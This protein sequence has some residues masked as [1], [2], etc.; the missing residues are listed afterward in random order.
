M[1]SPNAKPAR[2]RVGLAAAAAAVVLGAC[3]AAPAGPST[4]GAGGSAASSVAPAGSVPAVATSMHVPI[5]NADMTA[6]QIKAEV[7][8]EGELV[9]AN[10]SF[11][12]DG[13]MTQEFKD[14]IK[15]TYGAD[16]NFTYEGSF[17]PSVYLTNIYAAQ[18]GGNPAPYD[19]MAV[20]ENYWADAI[21]HDAVNS[22]LPS[23]LVP[24]QGL[25]LDQFQR[26]PT[27]I[28]FQAAAYPAVNYN[29]SAAPFITKLTDLAD[30]RLKGKVTLP[31]PGDITAGG[32]FMDLAA[33]LNKDYKDPDQ[34]KQ[35]VDWA[36]ANIGPNVL[37]YTS[38]QAEISQLLESGT[39]D[40]AAFWDGIN[41]SEAFNGHPE[42]ALLVPKVAYSV[43]GYMWIPKGAQHP[44]LAQIWI[45]WRLS[46]EVQFPNN[47]PGISHADWATWNEGELGPSYASS[48][49]SWFTNYATAYPTL[50][51]MSSYFKTVDWPAYN[52][53]VKVWMDYYASK[54]GQ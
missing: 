10:W 35:V 15:A 48:V 8:K 9:V 13:V 38:D 23:P 31:S 24:N 28:A 47:W 37:K 20:E 49:P 39:V 42:I 29:S 36:I 50:D 43:N 54:L 34:M 6:D 41:R 32:F 3:S 17:A 26:A 16:I 46:P 18:K 45:N 53:S 33:E 51:Q 7:A 4:S 30:A 25:V 11:P 27:A 21:A 5:L 40:A 14:Y 12:T 44:L 2:L 19:V 22:F 1:T 52:A